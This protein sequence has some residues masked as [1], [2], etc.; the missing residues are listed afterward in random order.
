MHLL[1][2]QRHSLVHHWRS[3]FAVGLGVAVATA[4]LT[5]ALLVGDSLRGS[6]RTAAL[7]RL[8]GV[9]YAIQSPGFFRAQLAADIASTSKYP[10][11]FGALAPVILMRG[12]ASQATTHAAARHIQV[13]GVDNRFWSL[14]ARENAQVA[15]PAAHYVSLN[16]AL[17]DDLGARPGDDVLLHLAKP[18][19]ESP[20]T[21]LGRRDDT[22]LTLRLTVARVLPAGGLAGLDLAPGQAAPRNAL[23]PLATLQHALARPQRVNTLLVTP[24]REGEAPAEPRRAVRLALAGSSDAT[25]SALLQSLCQSRATLADLGLTLRT[26]TD[27][28]YASL[29]SDAFLLAPPVE[30]GARAA[31]EAVD[32]R[33]SAIFAYLANTITVE[34]RPDTIV[35]YSIVAAVDSGPAL[36]A[37]LAPGDILLNDWTAKQLDA[38]SGD[39]VRLSYYVADSRGNLETQTATFRLAGI[40]PLQGAADDA[41][42]TPEYPGVTDAASLANWN[43]PFPLNLRLLRP[44][45]EEYW[46]QHRTTPKAF[47]GLADGQRRWA[48]DP[49][50]FGRLTALRVYPAATATRFEAE[51]RRRLDVAQFGLRVDAVRARAR[52]AS[53]GATDFGGLFLGF[54]LFLIAAAAMLIALLYRLGVEQRASEI[55]LL[56]ATGFRARRILRVLLGEG[57]L[58]VILGAGVGLLLARGY[59]VLLLAGLR[60]WWGPTIETS[61]LHFHATALSYVV[62][63]GASVLVAIAALAWALRGATRASPRALLARVA[64]AASAPASR[65]GSRAALLVAL[66]A[67]ITGIACSAWSFMTSAMPPVAAF[68]IGGSALLVAC[69]AGLMHWLRIEPRR[70]LRP[71]SRLARLRLGIR[72]ARRHVGRS[73]LTA[74]LIACA[75]FVIAAVQAFRHDA[76]LHQECT[77]G[78]E[79]L[80]ESDVPLLHDPNTP[81]C[82]ASLAL[83]DAA[84]RGLA[85]VR[86][87]A[88]RVHD[89]DEASC[90]NLYRPTEPRILGV[91][92]FMLKRGGFAFAGSLA[93]TDQQRRNP[94]LLLSEAPLDEVIPAIADEASAQW[95][96]HVGLSD[97]VHVTDERGQVARLRLVA[98]LQGSVLQGAVLI[99]E[100]PFTHLFPSVAGYRFFLIDAPAEREAE[101]ARTLS[102]EFSDYGLA[103]TPTAR[104]LAELLN[105]Q[106]VYLSAFQTLG[107]LGLLLGTLGLAAVMLRNVWERRGELALLRALGFSRVALAGVVLVENMFLVAVGLLIGLLCAALV[108]A[109]HLVARATPVPWTS[110]LLLFGVVFVAGL[111]AGTVALASALRAPLLPALRSE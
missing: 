107:G 95:Q 68:F 6:L 101:V 47:I 4:V 53:T 20:E 27:H 75:T 109:P 43:P 62:G 52:A 8:A 55:G 28:D 9:A 61:F 76:A 51:L 5:G 15:Q 21:A 13:L 30:T 84:E 57:V 67:I 60:S 80:A 19:A 90:L 74:G 79:L 71:R 42:F 108:D 59:A 98:L 25:E 16:Q 14:N 78:F 46:R 45:D 10:Q 33:T 87:V 56:L 12:S 64:F 39:A 38:R 73:L 3:S 93:H 85:D 18:A 92:D 35:P 22:T 2:L 44:Q 36:P 32:G 1:T 34:A 40:V 89:G 110:L 96:L 54:S 24:H 66:L 97:E 104:R 29:E 86:V 82:Q 26:S 94:W 63:Y 100:P 65:S 77:G 111:L 83:P 23:V 103:V 99:G 11:S 37:P 7:T 72:N 31:A 91:P 48:H 17:A 49:E 106:N 70:P 69:L 50:R 58:V 105:V 81:P 88:F 102:R 41:G